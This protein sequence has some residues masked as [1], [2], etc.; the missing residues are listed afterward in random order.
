[1]KRLEYLHLATNSI[2]SI[3]SDVK[4]FK[5]TKI[6]DVSNNKLTF[7][8]SELFL[9]PQLEMLNLSYNRISK[10]PQL[11]IRGKPKRLIENVDLSANELKQFPEY[12]LQ[13]VRIVDL[14]AN[15]IRTIPQT[16]LKKLDI[17]PG[18]QLKIKEN[19]L[20]NPPQEVAED[21]VKVCKIEVILTYLYFL[22]F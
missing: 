9:L 16:V 19:P 10:M 3:E 5:Y 13:I 22:P 18:Q 21:G 20:T 14:T 12:L 17:H 15:N 2:R 7:I 1:M 6:I 4:N 8:P 11:T